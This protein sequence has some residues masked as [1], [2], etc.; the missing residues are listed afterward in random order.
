[1]R[2]ANRALLACVDGAGVF[3]LGPLLPSGTSANH[4]SAV[5]INSNVCGVVAVLTPRRCHQIANNKYIPYDGPGPYDVSDPYDTCAAYPS[6]SGPYD[7]SDPYD[8][9]TAY[10]WIIQL[11][12][13]VIIYLLKLSLAQDPAN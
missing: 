12:H 1:M 6:T 11:Q 3:V 10:T 5:D 2:R 8:T 9:S 7:V 4:L 13:N